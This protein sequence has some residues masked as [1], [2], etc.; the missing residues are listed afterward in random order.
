MKKIFIK[1]KHWVYYAFMHPA[2]ILADAKKIIAIMR[3][4]RDAINS[5]GAAALVAAIPGTVDDRIL[6][7]VKSGLDKVLRVVDALNCVENLLP[8]QNKLTQNAI[9]CKTAAASLMELHNIKEAEADFIIQQTY[10]NY[11]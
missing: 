9:I 4:I 11:F 8:N 6:D 5:P 2:L 7:A 1:F 10:L 3:T